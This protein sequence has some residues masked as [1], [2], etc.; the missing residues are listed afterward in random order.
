MSSRGDG[1]IRPGLTPADNNPPSELNISG[2]DHSISVLGLLVSRSTKL[3][4]K[5]QSPLTSI[6]NVI[7]PPA[8]EPES[9]PV[10]RGVI[11]HVRPAIDTTLP[12]QIPPQAQDP[13]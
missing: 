7:D 10:I 13:L 9:D 6:E 11:V 12:S 5:Q 4:S 3:H 2:S 8:P 1:P